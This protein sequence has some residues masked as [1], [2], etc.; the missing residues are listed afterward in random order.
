M[1]EM[2]MRQALA[3]KRVDAE[4]IR[5]LVTGMDSAGANQDKAIPYPGQS[6]VV[7]PDLGQF[8]RLRPAVASGGGGAV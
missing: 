2:A 6:R 1:M 7:L 5:Q 4:R 8:D 3:E